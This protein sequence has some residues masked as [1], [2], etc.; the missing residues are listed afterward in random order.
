MKTLTLT[1]ICLG[2]AFTAS[3]QSV[4]QRQLKPVP[5]ASALPQKPVTP[6]AALTLRG[7]N[8]S[9]LDQKL[10]M[11]EGGMT[12]IDPPSLSTDP[13]PAELDLKS[14]L[15]HCRELHIEFVKRSYSPNLS[16]KVRSD[17]TLQ[18]AIRK[19]CDDLE[20]A[21]GDLEA[22]DKM[23]NF[24]IQDLMSQAARIR[25]LA[26]SAQKAEHDTSKAVIQ[27]VKP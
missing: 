22:Q 10:D 20:T 19:L 16:G 15:R 21:N 3:A 7:N 23:M 1:V 4:D 14:S 2:A 25:Q 12:Q 18:D 11:I 8:F 13:G 27:N 9:W 5:Q 24:E 17:L 26:R 6:R